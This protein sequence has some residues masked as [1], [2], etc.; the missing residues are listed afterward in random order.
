[1]DN[2]IILIYIMKMNKLKNKR[3]IN[4]KCIIEG[5]DYI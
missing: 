1:M 5:I 2:N 3:K 4:Y